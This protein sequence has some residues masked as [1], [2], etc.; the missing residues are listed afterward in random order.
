V[1]ERSRLVGLITDRDIRA[2]A[3]S[4]AADIA[5]EDRE[6]F[7]DH[8]RVGHVMSKKVFTV[9]PQATIEEAAVLMRQHKIGCLPVLEGGHLVGIITETDIFRVFLEVLGV[10]EQ[11]SRLELSFSP[12]PGYVAEVARI[13]EEQG[14]RVVSLLTFPGEE[15]GTVLILRVDTPDPLPLRRA[16]EQAGIAVLSFQHPVSTIGN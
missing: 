14:S 11:S 10:E 8:V 1:V 3:P 5:A 12:R 6:E 15:G 9:T 4:S 16:L 7:L 13:V 2:A